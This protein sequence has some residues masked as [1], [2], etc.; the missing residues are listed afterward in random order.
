MDKKTYQDRLQGIRDRVA[1]IERADLAANGRANVGSNELTG[2]Q[3]LIQLYATFRLPLSLSGILAV[4][5]EEFQYTG[6]ATR[7]KDALAQL[8][9]NG[10]LVDAGGRYFRAAHADRI[11]HER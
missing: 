7:I 9:A 1:Q 11:R 6:T 10:F 2:V 5:R 3:L 4:A 8:T